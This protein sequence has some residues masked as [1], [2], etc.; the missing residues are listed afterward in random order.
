MKSILA[1]ALLLVSVNASALTINSVQL[2]T[3]KQ[4]I[5][6]DVTYGGGCEEHKFELK[7]GA[8]METFPVMCRATLV[9]V[10]AKP[11][12]C[13]ALISEVVSIPLKDAG[14]DT[15]YYLGASMTFTSSGTQTP[16]H[17]ALP[18]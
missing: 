1:A 18:Q 16:L 12:F 4:A 5:D 17:L 6:F 2:N 7:V 11:D 13:E 9:D 3:E 14:L 10:S 8:C 15:S